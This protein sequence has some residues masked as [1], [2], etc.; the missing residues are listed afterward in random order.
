M[1]S[2]GQPPLNGSHALLGLEVTGGFME[3]AR[4]E[5]SQGLNC[6]IGGRGTG[7][8]T[9]LEF[10]RY[11]L[12]LMPDQKKGSRSRAH[13]V[14]Q[15]NLANGRIQLQFQTLHGMQ[16]TADRPWNDACQVLDENGEVREVAVG[17]I[18]AV[19]YVVCSTDRGARTR[20]ISLRRAT[21]KERAG[22]ELWYQETFG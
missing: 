20:V 11:V 22:Y 10:I 3:G 5:F 14:V 21:P 8:T 9:I 17:F 4:L 16:Y 7:K 19:P 1:A 18:G 6:I 12:G 13:S 2:S 15:S